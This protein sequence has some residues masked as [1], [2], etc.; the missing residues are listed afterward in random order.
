LV[1]AGCGS[2][3]ARIA[4]R[5]ERYSIGDTVVVRTIAGSVWGETKT[6]QAELRIGALDG[7]DEYLLGKVRSIAVGP[8][9]SIYI[10]DAQARAL[11]K[12][13]SDGSVAI[14][15]GREGSGPGEYRQPDSG[16]GVLPDGRVLL[17]DPENARIAVYAPDGT[18]LDHWRILGGHYS[19]RPIYVLPA[20]QALTVVSGTSSTGQPFTGLVRFTAMGRTLDTLFA[21]ERTVKAPVISL[22]RGVVRMSTD[23]PFW[24]STQWTFSPLGYFIVGVS[25]EYRFDQLRAGAVHR[26]ERVVSAVAVHAE[27]RATTR[28]RLEADYQ[29]R[30]P[31]WTWNGPDIPDTKP[32]WKR[33][34]A[35]RDGRMWVL[36]HVTAERVE[37]S[38]T[39]ERRS[40]EAAPEWREPVMFD[41]FDPD[42]T[43][44]GEV[45]A[46][47]D[48]KMAPEPVFNGDNVWAVTVDSL[49]VEFVTRFRL[50]PSG[51]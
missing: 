1:S 36:R 21:P 42:G 2:S 30:S 44:L 27:E 13:R 43:Y 9:E 20:G 51:E 22:R 39:D 41:V 49:G 46:P 47:N 26:V 48:M 28:H 35:G 32:L 19:P 15:L 18:P 5:V 38:L 17:R 7:S 34:F 14:T 23:V 33:I 31:D 8:D 12:Y 45:L 3:E 25:S 6:L 29:R 50:G 24:P 11:R 4:A 16:L 40:D 37:I 10:F